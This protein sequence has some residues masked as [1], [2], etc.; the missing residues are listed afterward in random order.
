MVEINQRR[1]FTEGFGD[2]L[3]SS[4][5]FYVCQAKNLSTT[6]NFMNYWKAKRGIDVVVVASTRRMDGTLLGRT[7]LDF[8]SGEV[9][10]FRPDLGSDTEGS[11]EIEI[12]SIDNLVFPYPAL[13]AFYE[14]DKTVSMV[15]SYARA[16]SPQELEEGKTIS[17]GAESN[18]TVRDG[19]NC[20]SFC[21]FHN[22]SIAQPEQTGRLTIRSSTNERRDVGISIPALSAYQSFK[23]VPC[24]HMPDIGEFLD[25]RPGQASLSF[26]LSGGFTRMLVGN[27]IPDGSDIQVTHSDFNFNVH[28]TDQVSDADMQGLLRVPELQGLDR[29]VVVYPEQDPGEYE[30][31]GT[32]CNVRFESGEHLQLDATGTD[33]LF[34][35]DR[36]GGALPTRINT[37]IGYALSRDFLPTEPSLGVMHKEVPPKR[38][39]W[40]PCILSDDLDTLVIAH[41]YDTIFGPVPNDAE[42]C[43]RLYSATHDG[44]LEQ[45]VENPDLEAFDAGVALD[46]IFPDA[47]T[48]LDGEYGYFTLYTEYGGLKAYV[49]VRNGS[50]STTLEHCF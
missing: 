34:A 30:V 17:V 38:M 22:G 16:Y 28:S 9:I 29:W 20:R 1:S 4:A 43:F 32:G 3:R 26:K 48:Y 33:G 24:N 18:W 21:V 42:F 50:G 44:Y 46:A 36:V 47:R 11:V 8:D 25:G 19:A 39:T 5:I 35:F 31:S 6:I 41:A 12:L 23:L 49:L 27:E 7:R 40:G 45:I 37:G 13:M 10:N 2:V 15:H 14:T